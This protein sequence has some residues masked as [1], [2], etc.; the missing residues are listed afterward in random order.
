LRKPNL[1]YEERRGKGMPAQ[2]IDTVDEAVSPGAAGAISLNELHIQPAGF[3]LQLSLDWIVLRASENVADLLGE[4]HVTLIEEPFSRFVQAQALHD[5]RNQFSRLSGTTGVARAY[6]VRLTDDRPRFDIAFQVV[7]SHVLLEAVPSPERGLGEALGSVGGLIE[8]LSNQSGDALLDGAARRVRAL[9][10]YDRCLLIAGDRSAESSR[11][12]ALAGSEAIPG[13]PAIVADTAAAPV[14][15]FP[16]KPND[17]SIA[18]ALLCSPPAQALRLL[19][20][21]GFGSAMSVPLGSAGE[22]SG[23]IQCGSRSSR[24]PNFELHAAT[25]LFAQMLALRIEAD[26]ARGA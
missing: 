24:A 3:L 5:L 15:I 12:Q 17:R 11:G 23:I 8:G 25:E 21:H 18:R 2:D 1:R 7:G 16:R 9:T 4:S 20:D 14:P 19:Q 10:G 6:R 13:L 22:P 26:R